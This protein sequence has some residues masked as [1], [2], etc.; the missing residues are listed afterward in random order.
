MSKANP[1]N[2]L[3]YEK[4]VACFIDIL[5]FGGIVRSTLDSAGK[6]N[7][8]QVERLR[9]TF[10]LI[11]DHLGLDESQRDEHAVRSTQFSDSIV[12]SFPYSQQ[13]GVW[14]ALLSILHLLGDLVGNELLCRGGIAVGWLLHTDDMLFGP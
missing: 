2:S 12:L 10:A 5:G 11:R 14:D 9:R 13:S 1:A 4:R 7:S 3:D 6:P 8:K